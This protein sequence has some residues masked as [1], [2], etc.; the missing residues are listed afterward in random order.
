MNPKYLFILLFL[1]M[2]HKISN[3]HL[4]LIIVMFDLYYLVQHN[5]VQH[6][7]ISHHLI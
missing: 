2:F 5:Q 3:D 4:Y 7:I 6:Q 1:I